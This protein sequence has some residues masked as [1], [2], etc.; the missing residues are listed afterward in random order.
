MGVTGAGSSSSLISAMEIPCQ[1]E[2]TER[3]AALASP[4][5]SLPFR[6]SGCD[7]KHHRSIRQA[8]RLFRVAV[9]TRSSTAILVQHLVAPPSSQTGFTLGLQH[10]PPNS[11]GHCV[12][13]GDLGPSAPPALADGLPKL[14]FI[15]SGFTLAPRS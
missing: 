10:L 8:L 15:T 5:S 6:E 3:P 2:I 7:E 4:F 13:G 9:L 12:A 1:A 11:P 14:Q